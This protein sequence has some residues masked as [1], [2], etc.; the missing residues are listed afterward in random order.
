[1]HATTKMLCAT[2]IVLASTLPMTSHAQEKSTQ[3]ITRAAGYVHLNAKGKK[4][5]HDRIQ[6]R[7]VMDKDTGLVWEL[8]TTDGSVHDRENNYRWGGTGAE[9]TGSGFFDDWNSL[10][11]QS[12][13]EKLCGFDDWRV[14]T[15][16][17]LKTLVITRQQGLA[18]NTEYFFDTKDSPYWSSSAYENYPEH[19]QTVHFGSGNSDYYNGY[20]GNRLPLRL[21]QGKLK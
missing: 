18:I 10:I 19:A 15:I 17:E 13:T 12:N 5:G 7:C 21:V 4:I 16:I 11:K 8:K 2:I 9:K 14:P 6:A 3:E 1:M 20:R